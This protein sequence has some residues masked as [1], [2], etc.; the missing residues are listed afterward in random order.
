MIDLL[1]KKVLTIDLNKKEAE[2]R[3]FADLNKY[4]GGV[5]LG[6][7]LL[8]I[9]SD[10]N[11][12]VLSIG[13]L[14]GFFP[15][16]SKTA[17]VL[18]DDGVIEDIYI[19]GSLSLRMRFAGIDAI[20]IFGRSDQPVVLDICNTTVDFLGEETDVRTLGLPGKRSVI[21]FENKKI[22]LDGYF[23]TP[24]SFLEK[25]FTEKNMKGMVITGTEIDKPL[26]FE[27]YEKLYNEILSKKGDLR[28]DMGTYPS[29]SNCP[30]G[31][32]KSKVGEIGGNVLI[33]SLVAC[34]FADKIY[35][36]IGIVFSCL[37]SLGY[38]YTHEDI[39]NL[40]KLIEETIRKIS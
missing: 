15:F 29:C 9:Y 31:C 39:E 24:E 34:Q 12:I 33:N 20:A 30:M 35:T 25:I 38:S 19:G 23:T 27:E 4:L 13:P 36:D 3:S 40:P 1:A 37:N 5:G 26:N 6:L 16:A 28:V 11:P 7:K 18:N 14:N 10:R 22:L 8:E 21:S 2:V 32:G 17:V